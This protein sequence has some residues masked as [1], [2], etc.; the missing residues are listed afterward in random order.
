MFFGLD[1]FSSGV[2]RLPFEPEAPRSV[3]L[4]ALPLA[5][6]ALDDERSCIEEAPSWHALFT[7]FSDDEWLSGVG[8]G[9]GVAECGLGDAARALVIVPNWNK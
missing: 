9:D 8:D 5:T 2:V 1:C 4:T 3:R 7:G 6:D